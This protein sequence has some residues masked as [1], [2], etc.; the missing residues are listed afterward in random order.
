MD[1]RHNSNVK[2]VLKNNQSTA[3]INMK[4]NLFSI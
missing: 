3:Q 4:R 2:Y 1:N